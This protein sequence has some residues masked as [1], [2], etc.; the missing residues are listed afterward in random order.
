MKLPRK[1]QCNKLIFKHSCVQK[2]QECFS[3]RSTVDTYCT[4]YLVNYQPGEN[5][6]LFQ[7]F[8]IGINWAGE[9]ITDSI[10]MVC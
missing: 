1:S 10:D 9:F 3:F 5:N 7:V 6:I 4:E 2:S 8:D